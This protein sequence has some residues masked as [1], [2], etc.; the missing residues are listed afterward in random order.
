MAD[1]TRKQ[2]DS[3]EVKLQVPRHWKPFLEILAYG[4]MTHRSP[5]DVAVSYIGEG[6]RRA[7]GARDDL[8]VYLKAKELQNLA[9]TWKRSGGL[10]SDDPGDEEEG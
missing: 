2:T 8:D 1:P 9:T 3:I 4:G 10:S 7:L 6:I 5:N